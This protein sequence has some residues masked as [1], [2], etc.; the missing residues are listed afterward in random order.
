MR[1][2]SEKF[3]REVFYFLPLPKGK[4]KAIKGKEALQKEDD[5]KGR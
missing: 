4:I 1:Y 3:V 5:G 2:K